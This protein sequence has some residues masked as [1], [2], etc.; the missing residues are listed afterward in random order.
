MGPF[1]QADQAVQEQHRLALLET[2]CVLDTQ[3][4]VLCDLVTEL[5]ATLFNT[6]IASCGIRSRARCC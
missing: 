5:A 2:Y 6:E 1:P 3:P 4:D